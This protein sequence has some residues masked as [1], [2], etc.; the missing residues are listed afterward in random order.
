VIVGV[1]YYV[2]VWKTRFGYDL[3]ASGLNPDAAQASGV[4]PRSMVIKTMLLSGAVAGLTGMM[5]LLS[6][7][8]SYSL[9]FP[10]GLGYTGIAVALV[11]RN[12][13]VGI[14]I[15]ALLFGFLERSAQILD[16]NNIPKEIFY[17]MEGI[18][19]LTVVVAYEVVR[20]LVEAQETKAAAERAKAGAPEPEVVSA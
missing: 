16:L 7:F 6:F 2:L 15:G 13:P 4:D 18:I 3:R 9:D 11:G 17:I 5:Y 10:T 8:H 1:A 20:R 12:N 14:A 19:I